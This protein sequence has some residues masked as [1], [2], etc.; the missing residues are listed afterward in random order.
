VRGAGLL[1]KRVALGVLAQLVLVLGG[2]RRLGMETRVV[3]VVHH[4]GARKRSPA[5]ALGARAHAR[6][7]VGSSAQHWAGLH[8][9]G[10]GRHSHA[11]LGV[12]AIQRSG[13]PRRLVNDRWARARASVRGGARETLHHALPARGGA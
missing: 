3:R 5:A 4:L 8:R 12:D 9:F 10:R 1:R 2:S 13:A 11:R 6:T 7:S